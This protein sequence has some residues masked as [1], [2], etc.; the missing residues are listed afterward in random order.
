M[1]ALDGCFFRMEK[2]DSV[3]KANPMFMPAEAKRL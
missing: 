2:S 1:E 3:M